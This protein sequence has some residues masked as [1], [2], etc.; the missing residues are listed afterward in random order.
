MA[1]TAFKLFSDPQLAREAVAA[2]RAG[3]Y[4]AEAIGVLVRQ[5]SASEAVAEAGG[6]AEGV[7]T[8]PDVGSVAAVG[9]SV[10]GLAGA[11]ADADAS[12]TL[13]EG[14]GLSPEA[15]S[16][17]YLTLMR[18]GVVVAVEPREGLPDAQHVM[19]GVEPANVRTPVEYNEAFHLAD[20]RT[21]TNTEDGQFSGDFRK[22]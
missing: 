10:F 7:G 4:P 2:L 17:F 9:A 19:R 20:R 15:L 6:Q 13:A 18:G 1:N 11:Q 16:T 12:A 14:F 8:L 3:G 21:T 22:Y 5:G